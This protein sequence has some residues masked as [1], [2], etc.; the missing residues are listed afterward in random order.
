[1]AIRGKKSFEKLTIEEIIY[2]AGFFDGEGNINIYKID[3]KNNTE[4]QRRLVPKYELSI[5][6]Y[7][8]DK[9]IME[10]LSSVFGGYFQVRN[11][12]NT[13]SHKEG[14]KESYAVRMTSNQAFEFLNLV[15]P[16]LRIK[17]KQADIAIAFQGVKI[18]KTSRFAKVTSEQ[19][20]FFE[21]S[22]LQ[23]RK[24]IDSCRWRDN[25]STASTR[26]HPQ[27]LSEKTL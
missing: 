14:W 8:T 12:T 1:M 27:R 16:Y 15:Y 22:Y 10:W 5:A 11:R 13:I 18:K 25:D 24:V 26:L 7:N 6:I 23:L 19:L 3:T 17:K 9:G 2:I 21:N 4:V 20:E